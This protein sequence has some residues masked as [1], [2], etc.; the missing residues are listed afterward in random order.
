MPEPAKTTYPS[1]LGSYVIQR[2]H[3]FTLKATEALKYKFQDNTDRI[4]QTS[5]LIYTAVLSR[6][7]SLIP[8]EHSPSVKQGPRQGC[9]GDRSWRRMNW[10]SLS[11]LRPLLLEPWALPWDRDGEGK[12]RS[13][14]ARAG[15]QMNQGWR[16]H[17]V[18][19][20]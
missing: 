8:E 18:F 14:P 10:C 1:P 7:D 17:S 4:T 2:K 12:R 19:R 6:S 5:K 9:R 16:C 3:L 11:P 20:C 15:L 13:C